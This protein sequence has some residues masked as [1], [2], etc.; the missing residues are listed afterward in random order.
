M[1]AL[2]SGVS[3]MSADAPAIAADITADI[4]AVL[5]GKT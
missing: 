1:A 2:A 3:G 5:T 4:T